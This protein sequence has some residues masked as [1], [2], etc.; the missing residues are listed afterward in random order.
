[1]RRILILLAVCATL[2]T[3]VVLSKRFGEQNDTPAVTKTDAPSK[4]GG[5]SPLPNVQPKEVDFASA[6]ASITEADLKRDLY[7]L[8]SNQLE[9]RMSGKAGNKLAAKY[10]DDYFRSQGLPT[11][12]HKFYVGRYN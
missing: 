9:G 12:R 6:V 3:A 4:D 10:I 5:S 1:M 11:M 2:T 7:Y 8:A